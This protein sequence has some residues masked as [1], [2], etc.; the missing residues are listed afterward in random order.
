MAGVGARAGLASLCHAKNLQELVL[1]ECNAIEI[2]PQRSGL[3]K[4]GPRY[5][6]A[7]CEEVRQGDPR[8]RFPLSVISL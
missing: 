6:G 4:V 5:G 3:R 2:T 8:N 1:R 7:D